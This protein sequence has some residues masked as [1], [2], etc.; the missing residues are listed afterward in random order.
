[1]YSK[2]LQHIGEFGD[3][4]KSQNKQFV[5]IGC[6]LC[7]LDK[8]SIMIINLF[9]HSRIRWNLVIAPLLIEADQLTS[10]PGIITMS[11]RCQ[12]SPSVQV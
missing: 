6:S 10:G 2:T 9:N 11:R 7:S 8:C 12:L 1:M 5:R 4:D 3:T